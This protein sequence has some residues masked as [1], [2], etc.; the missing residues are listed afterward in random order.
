MIYAKVK[1]L[2]QKRGI[3][4]RECEIRAGLGN[5]VIAGWKTSFPRLDSIQSVAAV[6]GVPLSEITEGDEN[7]SPKNLRPETTPDE[8]ILL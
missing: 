8:R 3:S 2:C 5:G 7:A 4:I 6:L 1:D